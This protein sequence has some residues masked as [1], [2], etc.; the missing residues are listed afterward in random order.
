MTFRPQHYIPCLRWKQGEYQ[1]LLNLSS[2]ARDSIVPII[3]V[4]EVGF[5][6]ESQT[7][8]KTID[9]HL[10]S[11]AKRVRDKWGRKECYVDMRYIEP[12]TQ[13][14]NGQHPGTF[15]FYDLSAKG[16][17]AIP[18]IRLQ[19]DPRF[20][21]AIHQVVTTDKRG[22]CLRANIEEVARVGFDKTAQNILWSYGLV[23]EQ[24]D[25]IVDL[26]TPN[27]DPIDSFAS[28]LTNIFQSLPNLENWRSF[29]MV[30]TS[31]PQ[32][33][34]G[35]N[36]GTT[37]IPRNEWRLYKLL[38]TRLNKLGGRI[39]SFGDYAINHP[40]VL[41]IDPRLIKPNA[42]IRYTINDKW[43]IAKGQNVRDHGYDQFRDLSNL[44][45]NSEHYCGQN[46]SEGD[47][48]IFKCAAGK[49]RTGNLTTW[50]RVGTNHHIEM[51]VRDVAKLSVS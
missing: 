20:Q 1:A 40:D 35:L 36:H 29:G 13:M 17:L 42:S 7:D 47:N 19:E 33:L 8:S 50:R 46:Y 49:E 14:S 39:P 22:L 48:F 26:V 37:F 32:S 4:A 18:V 27:F 11:F 2:L 28:L 5:D 3:E 43:L 21:A 38:V 41:S 24:C 10:F 23:I 15:V 31:F 9:Q 51:V 25:L 30:G 16:V 6:F 12:S 34:S 45:L 44:I